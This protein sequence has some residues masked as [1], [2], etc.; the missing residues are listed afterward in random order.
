M[1]VSHLAIFDRQ[2]RA[3]IM[4]YRTC[5][6]CFCHLF[7]FLLHS[8]V[9]CFCTSCKNMS[10]FSLSLSSKSLRKKKKE[11]RL[12]LESQWKSLSVLSGQTCMNPALMRTI[13]FHSL[14]SPTDPGC[15]GLVLTS[16]CLCDLG[17]HHQREPLS[18]SQGFGAACE[19]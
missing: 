2:V 19:D 12:A 3:K 6:C 14:P 13:T 8:I 5:P 15:C 1:P 17:S 10:F 7:L 4:T 18:G 9:F 16:C 11:Q